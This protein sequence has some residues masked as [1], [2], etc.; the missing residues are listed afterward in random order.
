[1][2]ILLT[3]S[4]ISNASPPP[5][6]NSSIL[7]IHAPFA[8]FAPPNKSDS[9][10]IMT[11]V[12]VSINAGLTGTQS[13]MKIGRRL[14]MTTMSNINL[15]SS[16]LTM[17]AMVLKSLFSTL[18]QN[19]LPPPSSVSSLMSV[20]LLENADVPD[21]WRLPRESTRVSST[22]LSCTT[23]SL[24]MA[25]GRPRSDVC[26]RRLLLQPQITR[27]APA[28]NTTIIKRTRPILFLSV[29]SLYVP[30]L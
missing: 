23:K 8:P 3:S 21:T 24:L 17:R 26:A 7:R 22:S 10:L 18:T 2:P 11:R 14:S 16:I 6:S 28:S 5:N 1:C 9:L 29:R 12:S 20:L 15:P 27:S 19:P 13:V 4:R 30:R 25:V